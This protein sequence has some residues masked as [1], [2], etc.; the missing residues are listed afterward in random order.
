MICIKTETLKLLALT[1]A[2]MV[3][4]LLEKGIIA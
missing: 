3:G 2:I 1:V 4:A